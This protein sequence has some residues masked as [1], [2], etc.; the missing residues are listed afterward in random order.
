MAL[1]IIFYKYLIS[2]NSDLNSQ[3]H[4]FVETNLGYK[5]KTIITVFALLFAFDAYSAEPPAGEIEDL[6]KHEYYSNEVLCQIEVC[7]EETPEQK[8]Q[9]IACQAFRNSP[10]GLYNAQKYESDQL[11]HCN[12]VKRNAD[13]SLIWPE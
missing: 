1:M 10:L 8:E 3:V 13:G 2:Q 12:R 4:N 7:P 5:T 11:D 6:E 9:R